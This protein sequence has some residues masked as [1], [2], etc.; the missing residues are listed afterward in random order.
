M[1]IY[2]ETRSAPGSTVESYRDAD[3]D[4]IDLGLVAYDL[5]GDLYNKFGFEQSQMPYVERDGEVC[6]ITPTSL[7][8]QDFRER[9]ETTS[10]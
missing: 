7:L 9:S 4:N 1:D 2:H 3:F 5:L 8:G 10:L 6:R